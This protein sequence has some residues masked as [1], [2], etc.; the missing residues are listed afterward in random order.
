MA[1]II[2]DYEGLPEAVAAKYRCTRVPGVYVTREPDR[3]K[4]DLRKINVADADRLVKAGKL[5]Q[6]AVRPPQKL[7][8]PEF[9]ADKIEK[10]E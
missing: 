2:H 8:P 6:L 4:V 5:P 9:P 1:T 10:H 3:E 7:A